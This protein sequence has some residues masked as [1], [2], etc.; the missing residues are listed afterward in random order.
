VKE[1][2]KRNLMYVWQHYNLINGK[3]NSEKKA[4]AKPALFAH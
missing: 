2:G 3:V 1:E 4:P